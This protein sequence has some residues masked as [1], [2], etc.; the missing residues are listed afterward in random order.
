MTSAD[1]PV[2]RAVPGY[3]ECN[4]YT[5][6][7]IDAAL[8]R[9]IDVVVLDP[10]RG[11]LRL[12]AAGRS[13]VTIESLSELT[14][15]TALR[16]CD[17]KAVTRTVLQRAGLVVAPGRLATFD[18]RDVAFLERWR[19]IV[20]KPACGE[21]GW[22]VAVGITDQEQL[23]H[24]V[25]DAR[26]VHDEVLLEARRPGD[27][28]RMLVIGGEMVA[29]SVRRPPSVVGDGVSTIAQLVEALSAE[30]E[31]ATDGASSIP[32]DDATASVVRAAGREFDDVLTA[33]ERIVVRRTANLHTGGTMH[34]VTDE[35]HPALV[36]VALRAARAIEI[37]VVGVDLIVPSIDGPDYTI[38]E[39]NEQPGLANHEPRPTAQRFVEL[40]FPEVRVAAGSSRRQTG[41]IS[42]NVPS[43]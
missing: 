12:T 43:T 13:I 26:E 27:D 41:S 28:V 38:I 11:E 3:D 33:G 5:T 40:L 16:R 20:V 1:V 30:R 4:R 31:A 14:S 36:D 32:L 23:A 42:T 25:A 15:A 9:G 22:G 17:H 35:V 8:E 2:H 24:A 7:I 10:K 6:I 21:Q 29:A 18:E 37:P 39:V 34:D 19:D